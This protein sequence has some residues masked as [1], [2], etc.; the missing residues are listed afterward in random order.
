[1]STLFS[2]TFSL[3]PALENVKMGAKHGIR[4]GRSTHR[5]HSLELTHHALE[6]RQPSDRRIRGPPCL[7]CVLLI[8]A[9]LLPR[10]R[11]FVFVEP[12]VEIEESNEKQNGS[13]E[14]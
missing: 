8:N 7:P 14:L 13:R 6:I 4:E 10:S 11:G 3:G 12:V 9:V 5:K 2:P 1:M